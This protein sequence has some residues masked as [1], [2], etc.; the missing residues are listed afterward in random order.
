MTPRHPVKLA[1]LVASACLV[2]FAVQAQP[3]PAAPSD[4]S[5]LVHR[6]TIPPGQT[7]GAIS[8]P[9]LPAAW[10]VGDVD[11]PGVSETQ[12]RG[13]LGRLVDIDVG[14][15]CTG[16]VEGARDYPC[17]FVVRGINVTSAVV[18]HLSYLSDW[19]AAADAQGARAAMHD[20][21]DPMLIDVSR[22]VRFSAPLFDA[23]GS[24]FGRELQFEIRAVSNPLVPSDFDRDSGMVV[25]RGGQRGAGN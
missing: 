2:V 23:G 17:G 14:G 9:L 8:V 7:W 3:A 21:D 5:L 13:I 22:F 12:L 24:T 20:P 15:R 25:L 4:D 16:C 10:R 6:F 11:G 18:G 1:A 19:A